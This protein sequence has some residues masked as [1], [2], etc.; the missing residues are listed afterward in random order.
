MFERHVI[1]RLF[2]KHL[3]AIVF[4]IN[5]YYYVLTYLIILLLVFHGKQAL[6][7]RRIRK[8]LYSFVY[9]IISVISRLVVESHAAKQ[10]RITTCTLKK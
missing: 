5:P 8:T 10:S 1:A 7:S 9:G 6:N 4:F 3:E 2:S